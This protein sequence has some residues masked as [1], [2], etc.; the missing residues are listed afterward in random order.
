MTMRKMVHLTVG[1]DNYEPTPEEL[2]KI[3]ELFQE[4]EFD[5]RGSFV[6]TSSVVKADAPIKVDVLELDGNTE[7]VAHAALPDDLKAGI[8]WLHKST[9]NLYEVVT[10]ANL[11]STKP[12]FV[13][14]VVYRGRDGA[15]WSRPVSEFIEKFQP[16][17]SD[18]SEESE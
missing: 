3:V 16:P 2:L 6:A 18:E 10:V 11:N 13:A 7:F 12:D 8:E 15:V 4:A 9:G 1:N 14:T 5:P 17:L